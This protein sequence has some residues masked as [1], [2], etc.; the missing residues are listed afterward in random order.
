VIQ[1]DLST[2]DMDATYLKAFAA[3][4]QLFACIIKE[5]ILYYKPLP[6]GLNIFAL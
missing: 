6:A 2:G 3:I 1:V 5:S 4:V